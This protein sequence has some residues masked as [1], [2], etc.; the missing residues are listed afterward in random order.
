MKKLNFFGIGP[1]IGI[2]LLP[3]LAVTIFLSC[4]TE[5]F[6]YNPENS[7][8][9]QFSGIVLMIF[10]LIFYFATVRMLLKGIKET[11]LVTKGAFYLCQNPLYAAIL[12]FVIPALSLLLNSWLIFTSSIVGYVMLKIH[13]K[14]EYKEL[15]IF[16]GED[17]LKY[18]SET[19]EFFPFP[20]K[21]WLKK[22]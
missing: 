9:L 11:R 5:L 6:R 1:K 7:N 22:I 21:K 17:Y 13:I 10:G 3:W 2:V 12:L 4:T 14:N 19:P 15:E 8:T 20:L 18:K 16:F